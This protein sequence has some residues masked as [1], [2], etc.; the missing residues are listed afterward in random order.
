MNRNAPLVLFPLG[1]VVATP[2]AL[3]N[4]TQEEIQGQVTLCK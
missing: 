3:A 2:N 1:A 4:L